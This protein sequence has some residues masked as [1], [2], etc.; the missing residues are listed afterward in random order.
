VGRKSTTGR[1]ARRSRRSW[2]SRQ[3]GGAALSG[4]R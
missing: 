4:L 1:R 3:E 2:S